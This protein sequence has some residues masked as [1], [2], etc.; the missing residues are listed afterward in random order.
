[1]AH[2]AGHAIQLASME[3]LAKS[4][5]VVL[6]QN[7]RAGDRIG[8]KHALQACGLLIHH[9]HSTSA[10]QAC[11]GPMESAGLTCLTGAFDLVAQIS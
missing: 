3:A 11:D 6:D 8:N 4:C 2:C 7:D 10:P 1:M 9:A 5:L